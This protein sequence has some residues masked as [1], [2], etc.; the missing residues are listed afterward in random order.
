MSRSWMK[1]R[2]AFSA[3]AI[4]LAAAAGCA[5]TQ[6]SCIDPSG[7]RV[8]APKPA[9]EAKETPSDERFFD[10]PM[11]R[12]PWD[13]A[14][15]LI[16]PNRPVMAPVGTEVVLV[17]GVVGQDGYLRTNRRLEWTIAP[18]GVGYFVAVEKGD[19]VDLLVGDFNWPRKIDSSTVIGS[20][21]R[22]NVR[23]N[24]GSCSPDDITLV[25]RG[26]GWVSLT[27]PVE[28]TSNVTV[29]APDVYGW[30]ERLQSTAVHWIDVAVQY[31]PPA[32][33]PAG[34]KHTFTTT[35]VRPSTQTPCEK[36]LVR[37][38]IVGGP[39]AGFSPD[40]ATS[41]EV[42]TN[43]VGQASVEISQ[44]NPV[45][46]ENTINI[47]VTRPGDAPGA[48][49]HRFV[50]ARGRTSK[51][52]SAAS[53]SVR[54]SGPG[55]AAVGSMATYQ[56]DVVNGGD[57]PARDV[58]ATI[59]VPNG[60]TYQ[61]SN[62]SARIVGP[63]LQWQLN[64]I[65][66]R[67]QNSIEVRFRAEKLGNAI[68]C[69][70]AATAGGLQSNNCV[71]TAVVS[72]D[73]AV[74][75]PSPSPAASSSAT[76]LDMQI[77][78]APDTKKPVLIGDEVKFLGKLGNY[79]QALATNA[80]LRLKFDAGLTH[81]KA[82]EK[83]EVEWR[84]DSIAPI[85]S[86]GKPNPFSV[87]VRATKSGQACLIATL[88]ASNANTVSR[89]V[90][91]TVG[92]NAAAPSPGVPDTTTSSPV[93]ITVT[94]LQQRPM[95]GGTTAFTVQIKNTSNAVVQNVV[96]TSHCDA[97]LYPLQSTENPLKPTEGL[98][99]SV[100]SDLSVSTD[101]IW[102]VG[103]LAAG[104]SASTMI[105]YSCRAS[106]PANAVFTVK[107]PN[108]RPEEKK[109]SVDIAPASGTP[110]TDVSP[111]KPV[112]TARPALSDA[113]PGEG[114]SMSVV[115]LADSVRSGK[116]LTYEIRVTNG[117]TA[118]C[119][120]VNVTAT[121]PDGL[122]PIPLGSDVADIEGQKVEFRPIELKSGDLQTYRLRVYAKQPGRYRLHAV[123]SVAAMLR[124]LAQD[125]MEI[126]VGN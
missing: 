120:N 53:L 33:N 101:L 73:A 28:G 34:T 121:V 93:S 37:Y 31:P 35:L 124:P 99:G 123:V 20:T 38:E 39:A 45:P 87:T 23:L 126:E 102:K 56:I 116:E 78:L 72:S 48:G 75:P 32:I 67:S 27:S 6:K 8:F 109:A 119:R 68:V 12:L 92:D 50:V 47:Q 110:G 69:C 114:L 42:P 107:L 63:Q 24:R 108:G 70:E 26:Q 25:R 1:C 79:G 59:A 16:E 83:G 104:A 15:V 94:P 13:D 100:S 117:G 14:A 71:T 66:P 84:F 122:T 118:T 30:R 3:A 82:N 80:V 19:F 76:T 57:I 64:E 43:A 29:V 4:C 115:S 88:S 85:A 61:S 81:P 22:S 60:L 54:A 90:C 96:A 10:D 98:W 41:I 40:G 18:G 46:G 17:A 55:M 74:S 7:Q 89:T 77:D 111:P 65:G 86:G 125:A 91:V 11:N 103:N 113:S 2:L 58:T 21:S 36:W 106:G 9:C 52:W 97:A 112:T 49:G 62:P 44:K 95:V 105:V 51:T 5:S